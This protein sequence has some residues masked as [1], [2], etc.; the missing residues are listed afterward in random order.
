MEPTN[1]LVI[2]GSF[3]NSPHVP[4]IAGL[5]RNNPDSGFAGR[6]S[7]LDWRGLGTA[8]KAAKGVYSLLQSLAPSSQ[9]ECL[10]PFTPYFPQCEDTVFIS[11]PAIFCHLRTQQADSHQMPYLGLRFVASKLGRCPRAL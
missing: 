5:G 6:L 9:I 4:I 8:V 1:T 7:E 3:C 11:L 2:L 10:F